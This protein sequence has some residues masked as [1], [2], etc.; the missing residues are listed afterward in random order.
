MAQNTPSGSSPKNWL[1]RIPDIVWAPI[2]SGFL[3]LTVGLLGLA[4]HQ[5]WLFPSLGPTAFL[6]AEQPDQKTARFHNTVVGHLCGLAA[7]LL[8]VMVLGAATAPPV[9]ATGEL[10]PVRVWASVLAIA[11]NML[12]G[13]LLKASHPPAAATTLLISL[14]GFKPTVS[15]ATQVVIGVLI[16]ASVGEILR[17]IRLKAMSSKAK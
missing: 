2:A 17:R 3:M 12:L 4:F 10:T 6:Q 15:D 8:A 14:G 9:L 13:F 1:S 16:V 5:P 7:G 11:L